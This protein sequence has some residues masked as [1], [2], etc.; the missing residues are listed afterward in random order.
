VSEVAEEAEESAFLPH[1]ACRMPPACPL[2]EEE[3]AQWVCGAV[4]C[5]IGPAAALG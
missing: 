5:V 4:F 1:A 2:R 3:R